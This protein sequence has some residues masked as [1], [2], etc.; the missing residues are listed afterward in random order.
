VDFG[1]ESVTDSPN[2]AARNACAK[3][4]CGAQNCSIHARRLNFLRDLIQFIV[5]IAD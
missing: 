1:L 4:F 5:A 2:V 3:F